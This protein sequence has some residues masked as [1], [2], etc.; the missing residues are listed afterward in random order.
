MT[1]KDTLIRVSKIQ[2]ALKTTGYFPKKKFHALSFFFF[3][4]TGIYTSHKIGNMA[5]WFGASHVGGCGWRGFTWGA[6]AVEK[7][8]IGVVDLVV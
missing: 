2:I 3:L 1:N 6:N 5:L 4:A 8:G 7:E